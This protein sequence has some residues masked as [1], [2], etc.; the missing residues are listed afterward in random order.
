MRI[1]R[2]ATVFSLLLLAVL[3]AIAAPAAASHYR[4]AT[5]RWCWNPIYPDPTP[6]Y[7]SYDFSVA[8]RWEGQAVGDTV[9]ETFD[10]PGGESQPVVLTV[11]EVHASRGWFLAEGRIDHHLGGGSS[12]GFDSCCRIDGTDGG[13]DLN[14]RSNGN[15]RVSALVDTNAEDICSPSV[16]L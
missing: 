7:Q 16:D 1:S 10:F 11:S 15:F 6:I 8:Y 9:T 14:N 2:R 3:I 12:A 4:Y 13:D 5:I